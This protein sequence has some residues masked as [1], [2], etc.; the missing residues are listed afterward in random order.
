MPIISAFFGIVI[1]IFHLDHDPPHIHATYAGQVAVYDIRTGRRLY[2]K[3]PVRAERLVQEWL[4]AR[5]QE[6]QQ[7]WEAAR[8]H[9]LPR[10]VKPL[11]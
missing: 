6:V 4:K 8:Q 7:A 9:R 3:L 2:G 5:R 1:R 11:E 10:K